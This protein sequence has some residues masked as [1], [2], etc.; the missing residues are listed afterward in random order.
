VS[1][2]PA[3]IR[4]ATT[5]RSMA[6]DEATAARMRKA[7]SG[8]RNV[9]EKKMMG[10]LCFMVNGSMC[11]TVSR[12]GGIL[13]RV[14]EEAQERILRE[15]H[16]SP[17]NIA[18]RAMTSFVLVEPEGYRT[19]AALKTWVARG[20]DYI[21]SQPAKK[22]RGKGNRQPPKAGGKSKALKA[23]AKKKAPKAGAKK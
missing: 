19:D 15:P 12:R 21:A 4:A 13:V 11:C 2:T 18:R 20:L 9:V 10:G 22:P 6:Y 16:V 7:L 8:Q 17:L 1:G 14:G 5:E 3:K 23:G